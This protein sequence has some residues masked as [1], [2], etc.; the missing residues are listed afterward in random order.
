MRALVWQLSPSRARPELSRKTRRKSS[1]TPG[2]SRR[3]PEKK[4]RP[5]WLGS[6]GILLEKKKE[7]RPLARPLSTLPGSPPLPCSPPAPLLPLLSPFP[8]SLLSTSPNS[9][10]HPEDAS[11]P[12]GNHHTSTQHN[13][14]LKGFFRLTKQHTIH[15]HTGFTDS[16]FTTQH[17][18]IGF[19]D[20]HTCTHQ[21]F[22]TTQPHDHSHIG[23]VSFSDSRNPPAA[24]TRQSF[25]A[26]HRIITPRMSRA[27]FSLFRRFYEVRFE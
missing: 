11:P 24:R 25:M 6:P 23:H 12:R 22:R 14:S 27:R 17:T 19:T 26:V 1:L 5:D 10:S 21:A 15:T 9:H 18:V 4:N 16:S 8:L 20:H 7:N 13:H 2:S 3:L